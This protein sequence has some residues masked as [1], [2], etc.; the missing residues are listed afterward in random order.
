MLRPFIPSLPSLYPRILR[1]SSPSSPLKVM[2]LTVSFKDAML[3]KHQYT[4]A[5]R[6]SDISR[7]LDPSYTSTSGSPH[8]TLVYVDHFGD[9]HDPD[10]RDFPVVHIPK[11]SRWDSGYSTHPTPFDDDEDEQGERDEFDSRHHRLTAYRTPTSRRSTSRPRSP[12]ISSIPLSPAYSPYS[13]YYSSSP[14][15]S[16]EEESEFSQSPPDGPL[17]IESEG[18]RSRLSFGGCRKSGLQ[19]PPPIATTTRLTRVSSPMSRI[20]PIYDEH[21]EVPDLHKE[22]DQVDEEQDWT[23]VPFTFRHFVHHL[24]HLPHSP[25]CS[26]AIRRQWQAIRLRFGLGF[27]RAKRRIRRRVGI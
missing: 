16:Y 12:G 3:G 13:Q 11:E 22:D 18:K 7:L 14:S 17:E 10:Y 24:T 15:Q 6:A 1:P 25:T 19:S 21:E 27:F 26:M 2:F 20:V 9:F 8:Q 4:P 23:Y 5:T